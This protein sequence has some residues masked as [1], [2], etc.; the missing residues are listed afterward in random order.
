MPLFNAWRPLDPGRNPNHICWKWFEEVRDWV[1]N[2]GVVLHRAHSFAG[3]EYELLPNEDPRLLPAKE[4][5]DIDDEAAMAW[6][7]KHHPCPP[8]PPMAGQVWA[9]ES[10]R[11]YAEVMVMGALRE[12]G[13]FLAPVYLS[14]FKPGTQWPLP[15]MTLVWGPGAPWD[16]ARPHVR[17][18]NDQ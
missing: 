5:G 11:T 7:D 3:W 18:E 1:R 14:G 13:G 17:Q 8:P 2:D 12:E 6:L 10:P 4:V 15:G 9:G 16:Y